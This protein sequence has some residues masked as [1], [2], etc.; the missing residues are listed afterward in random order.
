[1]QTTFSTLFYPRGNDLVRRAATLGE[2]SKTIG[3][4]GNPFDGRPPI[5]LAH[6]HQ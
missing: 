1:M 3:N 6:R 2:G 4:Q 5:L